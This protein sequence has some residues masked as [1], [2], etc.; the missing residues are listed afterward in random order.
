MRGASKRHQRRRAIVE[1]A[2]TQ[3]GKDQSDRPGEFHF[4]DQT[5]YVKFTA[6]LLR[7]SSMKYSH[8]ANAGGM[9]GSTCS[10]LASGKTQY[11][12]FSTIAGVLGAL[13]YETVIRAGPAPKTKRP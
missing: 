9:S 4:G 6:G 12:R 8:I 10:N 13:G 2:A 7:Q 5:D 3:R 11:P 1:S